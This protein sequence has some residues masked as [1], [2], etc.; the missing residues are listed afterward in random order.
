M[1]SPIA[2]QADGKVLILSNRSTLNETV[3][4]TEPI[5]RLNQDGS[6]DASFMPDLDAD[7]ASGGYVGNIELT[8][9]AD[10]VRSVRLNANGSI[11]TTF[12]STPSDFAGNFSS[13]LVVLADGKILAGGQFKGFNGGVAGLI[14]LNSDGTIDGSFTAGFAAY[15]QWQD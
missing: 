5:A 14:R 8:A 4:I 9:G 11:D 12:N 7:I 15:G 10:Q 1:A 6:L 13:S 2:V 3:T